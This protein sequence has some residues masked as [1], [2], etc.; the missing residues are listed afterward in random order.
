MKK[1]ERIFLILALVLSLNI[2]FMSH[3][4]AYVDPSVTTYAIQAIVGVVVA[5]GAVAAI[6]WR[7]AKSQHQAGHR[8]KRQEDHR[9]RRGGGRRR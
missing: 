9:G 5:V 6:W 1:S 2:A 4:F 8:R 7:K 3:A